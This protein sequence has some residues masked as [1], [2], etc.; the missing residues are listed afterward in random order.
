MNIANINTEIRDLTDSNSTSLTDATLLRRVNTAYET[1]ISWIITADG[2]WQ[3]DDTN[4]TDRSE[5]HTS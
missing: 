5:K 2:T 3:F 4:F 1:V